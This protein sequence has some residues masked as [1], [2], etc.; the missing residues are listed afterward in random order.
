MPR[1]VYPRKIRGSRRLNMPKSVMSNRSLT[2]RV[3]SLTNQEGERKMSTVS[4]F[5]NVT[6]TA[7]TMDINEIIKYNDDDN[8]LHSAKIFLT[9]AAAAAG[10][11]RVIIFVDQ[12]PS[13]GG[14]TGTA[15]LNVDEPNGAYNESNVKPFAARNNN[16]NLSSPPRFVIKKDML[17]SHTLSTESQHISKIITLPL[18]GYK[19]SKP[20]L[21]E[22][23][24][25]YVGIVSD[26]ATVVDANVCVDYTDLSAV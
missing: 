17:F 10:S 16:K 26:G 19:T 24:K 18:Y 2:R 3:R 20:Y 5:S 21:G 7:N 13:G 22:N 8:K 14:L 4:L 6:L 9:L 25:L 11:T 15:V 12:N 1:G 23:H